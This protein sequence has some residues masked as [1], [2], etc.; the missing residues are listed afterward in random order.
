MPSRLTVFVSSTVRDFAPVRR[1]IADWLRGRLIDVRESED[2]EFPVDPGVHS[3]EACLRAIDGCHVLVLLVGWRYGGLFA[4]TTQ[5]IT[6]REYDEA[7]RLGVP[8]VA[9]VLADV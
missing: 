8:V 2:P 1:D 4:G 6:W 5:S 3:Q 9:F 7:R